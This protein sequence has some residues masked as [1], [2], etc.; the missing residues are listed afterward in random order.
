MALGDEQA[1]VRMRGGWPSRI[2]DVLPAAMKKSAPAGLMTEARVRKLWPEVVGAQIGANAWVHR[3]RG[4]TLEVSVSA[5]VWATELRYLTDT[6]RDRINAACGAG[7]VSDVV[8]RR[9]RTGRG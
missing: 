1:T 8:I 3:L 5:D 2:G 7:T 6:I 4:T 9:P